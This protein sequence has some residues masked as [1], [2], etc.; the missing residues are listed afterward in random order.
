M[1]EGIAFLCDT[2]GGRSPCLQSAKAAWYDKTEWRD[3]CVEIYHK[4]EFEIYFKKGMME[5][6]HM[7]Q[8]VELVYVME[9]RVRIQV[10]GKYF[11]LKSEDTIV[12]NSNHRH[13]WSEL[14]PSYLCII[15]F[16]YSMLL[17]HMDK[18]LLFFYCNSAVQSSDYYEGIRSIME[19]LL[20]EYAVNTDVM[21]FQ[22]KSVLYRLTHYLTTYFMSDSMSGADS[23]KDMRIEK[24]LQYINANYSRPIP[25]TELASFLHMAPTSFSRFFKRSVGITFVEYIN[26]VRLH[27]AMEDILYTNHSVSWIANTHG[28]TNASAF[29]RMFKALYGMSPLTFRKQSGP[30]GEEKETDGSDREFLKKYLR[31]NEN[32]SWKPERARCV[33]VC[34]SGKSGRAWRVPWSDALCLGVACELLEARMQEQIALAKKALQFTYGRIL[35]IFASEMCYREGHAGAIASYSHMDNVLDFLVS[36]KIRPVIS[37]DNKPR[38]VM[39]GIN[40]FVYEKKSEMIFKDTAECVGVLGDFLTHII[41][42]YGI[43]EVQTWIFDCWWDEFYENTMGLAGD[44]PDVFDAICK[45]I[46]R[47]IPGAR[48][49]GC[50]LSPSISEEKFRTLLQAWAKKKVRPDFISINLFPYS[51]TDETERIEGKR[52]RNVDE[53]YQSEISQCRNILSSVG[54]E[55]MP[56]YVSEWNMSLSQRNLFNDTCGK[57]ALMARLMGHLGDSVDFA[58]YTWLSDYTGTYIDAKK[59][60]NGGMG[61][62]TADGVPKPA[63]YALKFM[64]LLGNILIHREKYDIVTSADGYEFRILCFN[65]KDLR[66]KYYL[67][68]ENRLSG[69]EDIF[70]NQELLELNLTIEDVEDGEWKVREYRMAPWRNC[71]YEAWQDMGKPEEPDPEDIRYL[72][73]ICVPSVKQGRIKTQKGRLVLQQSLW[74]QEIKFI[75]IYR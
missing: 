66:Y 44:F 7:H 12:I 34:V 39:K 60:L 47:Y 64:R 27:F 67:S 51:R 63:F 65:A 38:Y 10:L 41:S 18:K 45:T 52:R 30:A 24:M 46:R 59:L 20:S 6:E 8:D 23:E 35:G 16:N 48:A 31:H 2:P 68:E 56:L 73:R 17:E 55:D 50:G 74:A 19:D 21:T 61:L 53:Y 5:R 13:S 58:A 37:L 4:Q 54:W 28:F 29:C 33:S 25:L 75:R 36:Q 26:N 57:A 32:T 43:G 70:E 3:G 40:T 22:K 1:S 71:V 49:G 11:D 69:Q 72:R 62:L 15:H 14:E 42:R 9:G